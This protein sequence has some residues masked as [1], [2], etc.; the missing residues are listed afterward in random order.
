MRGMSCSVHLGVAA[1]RAGSGCCGSSPILQA[2]NLIQQGLR[3]LPTEGLKDL[4]FEVASFP[5]VG[6]MRPGGKG[7]YGCQYQELQEGEEGNAMQISNHSSIQ[8]LAVLEGKASS[9]MSCKP[10]KLR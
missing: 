2:H 7:G 1:S 6:F 3:I 10:L 8:M 9:S 5:S 4:C